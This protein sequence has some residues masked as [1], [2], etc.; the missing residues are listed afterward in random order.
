[1]T[2]DIPTR[3]DYDNISR[4]CKSLAERVSELE[5]Q[6]EAG[7]KLWVTT[8]EVCTTLKVTPRTLTA[9]ARQGKVKPHKAGRK[10]LYRSAEINKMI[11]SN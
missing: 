11:C 6:N 3:E 1:M 8:E 10:N 2:I 7:N 9:W 5:R 4:L